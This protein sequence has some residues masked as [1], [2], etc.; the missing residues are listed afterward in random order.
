MNSFS[1]DVV[2]IKVVDAS[3]DTPRGLCGGNWSKHASSSDLVRSQKVV[4]R[5]RGWGTGTKAIHL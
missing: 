3:E 1:C 5:I 2:E 4:P